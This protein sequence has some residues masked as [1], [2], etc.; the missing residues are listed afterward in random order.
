MTLAAVIAN[1]K[2]Q[3]ICKCGP[4]AVSAG[5]HAGNLLREVA[6]ITGGGGGGRPDFATAGGRDATKVEEALEAAAKLLATMVG[7]SP[8]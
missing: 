2:P 3:F 7:V 4:N 8:D 5:A 1:G 6:K